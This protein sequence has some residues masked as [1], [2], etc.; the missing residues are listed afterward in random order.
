MR[1]SPFINVSVLCLGLLC[2]CK[3]VGCDGHARTAL[4]QDRDMYQALRIAWPK[5]AANSV[6]CH[7]ARGLAQ[8]DEACRN[9]FDCLQ[10]RG[11]ELEWVYK[12]SEWFLLEA[13]DSRSGR[14]KYLKLGRSE[15]EGVDCRAFDLKEKSWL[16][17]DSYAGSLRFAPIVEDTIVGFTEM[18]DSS[19]DTI[20][21]VPDGFHALIQAGAGVFLLRKDSDG[22]YYRWNAVNKS[23]PQRW[24][25]YFP[26]GW[27]VRSSYFIAL[28]SENGK[29]YA[30]AVGLDPI[31]NSEGAMAVSPCGA[32]KGRQYYGVWKGAAGGQ[33][34]Y[35][36]W[37]EN[38]SRDPLSNGTETFGGGSVVSRDGRLVVLRPTGP[39]P[40]DEFWRTEEG[41]R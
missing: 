11:Y 24:K 27:N 28:S 23:E 18:W 4:G 17:V 41:K 40:V 13:Q 39:M 25:Y 33:R 3:D 30:F 12:L 26:D 16:K 9:S 32:Y 5:Y 21:S 10:R 7:S 20:V 34:F 36:A 35:Y 37:P 29:R 38:D 14:T 31:P 19:S 22:A 15:D 6:C 1:L 8:L 2:G